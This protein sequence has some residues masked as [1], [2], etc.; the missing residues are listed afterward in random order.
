[1][2]TLLTGPPPSG[3]HLAPPCDRPDG[4]CDGY[5]TWHTPAG[6]VAGH[7]GCPEG[8]RAAEIDYGDRRGKPPALAP[9]EVRDV[10][11]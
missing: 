2:S 7:C 5:R 6:P 11:S 3:A 1:M 8:R 10:A 9:G 4:E